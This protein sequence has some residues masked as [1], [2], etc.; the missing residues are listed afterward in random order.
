MFKVEGLWFMVER[1]ELF[2]QKSTNH[3]NLFAQS[4]KINC[5]FAAE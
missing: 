5:T 2:S 1:E 3:I 4:K